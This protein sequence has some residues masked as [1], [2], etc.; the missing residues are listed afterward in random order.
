MQWPTG[1]MG[2]MSEHLQFDVQ[3]GVALV[4]LNRPEKLNAFTYEMLDDWVDRL[5]ECQKRDDVRAVVITGSGRGFCTGADVDSFAGIAQS[6]PTGIKAELGLTQRL[7]RQISELDK[8]VIAAING[9]A[10]GG[11]LDFALACDI[12]FA[13]ESARLAETYIRMGLLP[14]VGG[15]YFLTQLVGRAKALELLWTGDFIDAREAERIGLVNKVFRDE[16][17]LP[18]TLEFAG[19]LARSAPLSIQLIKRVV[20]LGE[21]KDLP[22]ALELAGANLTVVRSSEDHLEAVS[23]FREKREAN[24]KGR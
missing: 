21:N 18:R 3:D 23:A 5:A 20:R 4:T 2:S 24:F 22:T 9:F 13:A 15:A 10:T 19:R 11:G 14:G 7:P 6:G 16:E 1:A 8:P 12:R 17:L